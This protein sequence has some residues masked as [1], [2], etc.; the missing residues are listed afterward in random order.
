MYPADDQ[1][2]FLQSQ[3]SYNG[4]RVLRN[5]ADSPGRQRRIS[6]EMNTI[7]PVSALDNLAHWQIPV[8]QPYESTRVSLS[9]CSELGTAQAFWS[10]WLW[11][12]G[13]LYLYM[14]TIER[15]HTP[16]NMW[17]KVKLSNNYAKALEQVSFRHR[18]N[19]READEIDRQGIDLLAKFH[20]SQMQAAYNQNHPIP[21]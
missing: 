7:L 9:V 19:L 11:R 10:E 20:D 21:D 14:K 8:M 1:I 2:L 17:E 13:V 12:S 18:Y 15:A 5:Q 16:A 4:L 3:V 6:V